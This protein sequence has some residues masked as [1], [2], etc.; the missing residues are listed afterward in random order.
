MATVCVISI[1]I[2]IIT[3]T[4]SIRV[5]FKLMPKAFRLLPAELS[6]AHPLLMAL[7][8]LKSLR[9][10]GAV[11]IEDTCLATS[12]YG[13]QSVAASSQ[14]YVGQSFRTR[15][16]TVNVQAL[17]MLIAAGGVNLQNAIAISFQFD[18]S[19]LDVR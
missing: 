19:V 12:L 10:T 16:F 9:H 13:G 3:M 1:I 11:R 15:L 7:F 6:R 14:F 18:D 5:H 8:S 17:F 4:S 2:Y